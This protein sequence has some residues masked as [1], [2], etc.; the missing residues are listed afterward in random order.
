MHIE[1]II[2]THPDVKGQTNP[3]LIGAIEACLDCAESCLSC[4][5][6]CLAEDKVAELRQCI[7]LDN[8]CADICFVTAR[9]AVR[10]TGGN[11]QLI[12]ATLETCATACRLCGDECDSHAQMHEHCRIC[13]EACRR[14][15]EACREAIPTL[16]RRH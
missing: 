7:R 14:C 3:A 11:E 8:D 16:G 6:A 4:A 2:A 15:E 9:L 13:A 10:R 1:D 12:R 5:D